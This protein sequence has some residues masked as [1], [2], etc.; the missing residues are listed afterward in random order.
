L[1]NEST[2]RTTAACSECYYKH[3]IQYSYSSIGFSKTVSKTW[4]FV[5]YPLG[6]QSAQWSRS[7]F[8]GGIV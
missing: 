4:E 2:L 7:V 5:L 8:L 3:F 1:F 6:M